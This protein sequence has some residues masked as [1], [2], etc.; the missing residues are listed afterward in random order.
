L[1]DAATCYF[2]DTVTLSNFALSGCLDLIV[3]R[4]GENA[5]VTPQV[6]DEILDGVVAGYSALEEIQ[7]AAEAGRLTPTPALSAEER[8]AYRR[9]VQTLSPG[10]ASCISC[11]KVRGGVVAT[12]DM[13]AR[14]CYAEQG[15]GFTGTVGILKACAV[16]QVITPQ[17]ADALLRRMVEAGFY[18]PVSHVSSLL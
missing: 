6:M 7:T 16:D 15:I 11:A 9:L 13:A 4:Y 8:Q 17:N 14:A 1:P 12:D 3:R 18:S 5:C 2:F 10:E